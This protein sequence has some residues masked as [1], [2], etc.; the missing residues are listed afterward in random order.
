[1]FLP[2]LVHVEFVQKIWV[3]H[4]DSQAHPSEVAWSAYF[5]LAS[6]PDDN[7]FQ[8]FDSNTMP[9]TRMRYRGPQDPHDISIHACAPMNQ[10]MELFLGP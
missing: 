8:E 10:F 7:F 3:P 1:M 4:L 5:T 6:A 9:T 2:G